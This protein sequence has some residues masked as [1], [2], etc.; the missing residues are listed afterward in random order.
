MGEEDHGDGHEEN[1]VEN[2]ANDVEDDRLSLRSSAS[3]RSSISVDSTR[4]YLNDEAD[5][6]HSGASSVHDEAAGNDSGSLVYSLHTN[7]ATFRRYDLS[8]SP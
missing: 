1:D 6:K 7:T 8:G 4:Q 5:S 3:G 2:E